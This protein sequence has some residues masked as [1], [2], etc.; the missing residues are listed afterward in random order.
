M[1]NMRVSRHDRAVLKYLAHRRV[2]CL[3]CRGRST[4]AVLFFPTRPEL[5]GGTA[6]KTRVL[7]YSL[8]EACKALPDHELRAEATIQA[9]L[10]GRRN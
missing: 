1:P 5:W 2:P 6:G 10:V 7:G 9:D 8:C 4:V 3:L